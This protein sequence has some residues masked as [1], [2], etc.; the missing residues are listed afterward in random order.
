MLVIVYILIISYLL[1]IKKTEKYSWLIAALA[2][3]GLSITSNDYADIPNYGPLFDYYNTSSTS[4]NFLTTNNILWALLCK[5]FFFLGFNYRGMVACLIFINYYLLHKAAKNLNCNENIFFGLFLIFP[6]MI[7][8]IQFKFFTAS[9]LVIYGYSILVK[10]KKYSLLIYLGF[11]F[12][13]YLIHSSS[14]MFLILALIKI[15][16]L[17]KNILLIFA[18]LLSVLV[19]LTLDNISG[20]ISPLISEHQ[21]ERYIL[22]STTPSS[23]MWIISILF[24]WFSSYIIGNT[25]IKYLKEDNDMVKKSSFIHKNI[26]SIVLLFFTIPLLLLDRN[27]NRFLYIGFTICFFILGIVFNKKNH[28]KNEKLLLF[29]TIPILIIA[30]FVNTPYK[31]GME[32]FFTYDGIVNLRGG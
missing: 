17:N 1:F 3:V 23:I 10:D 14:I 9:T 31:F 25:S 24:L 27:M 8:L 12:L 29:I 19:S 13:A 16:K 28:T 32:E 4:I 6:S 20:L 7:Q 18:I 15:K 21:Y 22:N 26:L 2:I 30:L 5:A 11:V